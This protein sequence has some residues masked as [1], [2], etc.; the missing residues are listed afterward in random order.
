MLFVIPFHFFFLCML[1]FFLYH[2]LYPVK[3]LYSSKDAAAANE[4][5]YVAELATVSFK[6]MFSYFLQLLL[7][8]VVYE[9]VFGILVQD[10]CRMVV[11]VL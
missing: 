7:F 9:S 3:E 10:F 6:L 11:K 1:I 5:R 2:F 8:L 4:D